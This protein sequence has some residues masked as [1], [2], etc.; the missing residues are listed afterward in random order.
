[1]YL[2]CVTKQRHR[3][4]RDLSVWESKFSFSGV[5]SEAFSKTF[6]FKTNPFKCNVFFQLTALLIKRNC[7]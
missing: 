6:Q 1:M 3:E 5:S 4:S 7:L 2:T